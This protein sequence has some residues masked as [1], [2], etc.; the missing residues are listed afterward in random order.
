[1]V[2]SGRAI[3]RSRAWGLAL[4]FALL[5]TASLPAQQLPSDLFKFSGVGSDDRQASEPTVAAQVAD[6]PT[7]PGEIQ[8]S[9]TITLPARATTY[10]MDPTAPKKTEI[11][12]TDA[13]GLTPVGNDF[14]PDRQPKIEFEELFNR[15][16]GKFYDSV[17]FSRR[18]RI[19]P[20]ATPGRVAGTI[21]FLMCDDESCQP[22]QRPFEALAPV[23]TTAAAPAAEPPVEDVASPAEA[24]AADPDPAPPAADAGLVMGYRMVPT[25][26]VGG[27]PTPDPVRLQF[28]LGPTDAREGDLVTLAITMELDQNWH[29]YSLVKGRNQ[30][31]L[32]TEL[33][34]T[35]VAGLEAQGEWWETPPPEIREALESESR[36]HSKRVTW[37]RQFVRTGSSDIGVTGDIQYQ[38]CEEG[39]QCK[40]PKGVEFAL[41]SLQTA[42][43]LEDAAVV[44]ASF[45]GQRGDGAADAAVAAETSFSVAR[46]ADTGSL[47]SYLALAFLGGLTLNVMPCVLPVLAIKILSFVQQAGESRGRVLT[48]NLVYT[49]GVVSVFMAL[50][51]LAAFASV[52]WG[53]VFQREWFRVSM[54]LVLFVVGLNM[55]GV[56]E[57]V[58]PGVVN[59]AAGSGHREGLPGAF[60]TGIF[61]TLLATPC[62][63]GWMAA[64]FTW[65]LKQST[66]IIF[67]VWGVMGLG[68]ASPYLVV[69]LFPALVNWLPRPGMWMVRFKQLSAFALFGAAVFFMQALDQRNVFPVL[70]A[71]IGVSLGLWMIGSMYDRESTF[72]R[73]Q[74][75]RG[76]ALLLTAGICSFGWNMHIKA[77]TPLA[78]ELQW[79]AFET[80]AFVRLRREGTP[81]L[82]DFTADWCLICKK[83]EHY[84]LN[85]LETVEFVKDHGI[86]PMMA[87]W[88]NQD[89]EIR[90]WLNHFG[91]DSVPLTVIVPPNPDADLITLSGSYSKAELLEKLEAAMKQ[92]PTPPAPTRTA[93]APLAPVPAVSQIPDPAE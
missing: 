91:Q 41:G 37:L 82:V 11:K 93:E 51:C 67:L 13:P 78:H 47:W 23:V 89:D 9:I 19:D 90:K 88:T 54:V 15:E 40:G 58:L 52:S 76:A 16:V 63:T 45:L 49:L 10:G 50:A 80:E 33:T 68:M 35:S 87:D 85:T 59:Q 69:G 77:T 61:A 17:T 86:V 60:M 2:D 3:C 24:A 83:N 53:G 18:Y 72:E 84:S 38:I 8:L 64:A 14:M 32:P 44:T 27:R 79:K 26:R 65:S 22:F 57:I 43:V 48:L 30:I 21:S 1:M 62:S 42:D 70:V 36:Q 7:A 56:F 81:V 34:L 92:G 25:R 74:G 5:P 31:E 55:M 73:K 4:L 46:D 66:P 6:V 29:V 28:E 39:K 12:L 20:S 71:A 75:V